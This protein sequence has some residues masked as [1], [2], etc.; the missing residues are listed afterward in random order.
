MISVSAEPPTGQEPGWSDRRIAEWLRVFL[1]LGIAMRLLRFALNYPLWNDEAYLA[2]NVLD[3]DYVGLT[4]PLDYQ[5][6][7]PLLFLWA[8][9]AVSLV[10][11]VPRMV[12][13]A[14]ADGRLDREPVRLPPRRGATAEGRGV[15]DRGGDP[16]GRI[17]AHPPRG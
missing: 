16:G 8:E 15:G 14:R 12:V 7:C 11:R 13:A 1:A 3:R 2:G 4:R 17:Y 5:Q 10:A 6:V 9:K